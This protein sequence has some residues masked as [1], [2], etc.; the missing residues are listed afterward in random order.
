MFYATRTRDKDVNPA[1]GT[2]T[3][4]VKFYTMADR[5]G[6][7]A[8]YQHAKAI[9]SAQSKA[10]DAP[11]GLGYTVQD[12]DLDCVYFGCI[13][14]LMPAKPAKKLMGDHYFVSII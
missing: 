4:V 3:H 6:Y 2:E 9:S 11:W 8:K 1:F 13:A 12:K 14:A 7:L 10:M 5:A